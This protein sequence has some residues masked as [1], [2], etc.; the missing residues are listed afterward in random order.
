MQS[1]FLTGASGYLGSH[2]AEFFAQAGARVTRHSRQGPSLAEV[3]AQ[4]RFDAV[5]N[6]ATNYGRSGEDV[7]QVLDANLAFPVRVLEQCRGKTSLFINAG[8]SLNPTLNA[9]ALSKAQFLDWGRRAADQLAFVNLELEMFYG[10]GQT[11]EQFIPGTVHK[12]LSGSADLPLTSGL[13][14]R[15]LVHIQDV[16]RAFA[17]VLHNPRFATPGYHAYRVSSLD[18]PTI[19]E[20][21]EKVTE[22]CGASKQR[23]KFGALP[24]RTAATDS[25]TPHSSPELRDLGWSP[26]RSLA[27]GLRETVEQA[28]QA[29][30]KQG[31]Q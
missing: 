17:F 3:F 29:L 2:L 10:P 25:E 8:T 19:R 6:C 28:Q 22:F 27:D 31:A 20:V 11:H 24:G 14:R 23:L 13:Q 1:I 9:Y 15:N 7:S 21:V 16:V 4:E 5:L 26:Q 18:N 30:K 12:L